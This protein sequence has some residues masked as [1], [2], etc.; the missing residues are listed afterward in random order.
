MADLEKLKRKP[1]PKGE[2]VG[3]LYKGSLK[4]KPL[5]ASNEEALKASAAQ[6]EALA[7]KA[8]LSVDELL[9]RAETSKEF[10]EDDLDALMLARQIAY[11]K[12]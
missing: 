3:R 1:K 4:G 9:N 6:L 7:Q 10:R 2:E 5:Y 11:F 8:G 12:K